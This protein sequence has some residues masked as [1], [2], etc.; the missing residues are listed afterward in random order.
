VTRTGNLEGKIRN[1]RGTEY[2]AVDCTC[3]HEVGNSDQFLSFC[4]YG[5]VS[6]ALA[7]VIRKSTVICD[8]ICCSVV[9]VHRRLGGTYRLHLQGR[10]VNRARNQQKKALWFLP[11]SGWFLPILTFDH[12]DGCD[13]FFGRE[14]EHILLLV[15]IS[16]Y[17]SIL[18]MELVRSSE[19]SMNFHRTTLCYI[20]ENCAVQSWG[21]LRWDIS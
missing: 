18:K 1:I 10:R 21:S 5:N 2:E 13:T 19:T 7:A 15:Y 12:E 6:E 20:P 3:N 9:Q 14:V 11:I 17:C 16:D 8:V 4:G